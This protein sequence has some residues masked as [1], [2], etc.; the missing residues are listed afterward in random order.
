MSAARRP[1]RPRRQPRA[2]AGHPAVREPQSRRGGLIGGLILIVHRR[3]SSWRSQFVPGLDIG[4][5]W[6]LILIAIGISM[7]PALRQAVTRA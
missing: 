3:R 1:R 7:H 6:P 5:L 2:R 4:A